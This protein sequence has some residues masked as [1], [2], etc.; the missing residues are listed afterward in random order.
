MSAVSWTVADAMLEDMFKPMT[1]AE[2]ED[3]VK[4]FEKYDAVK[5]LAKGG[6][7]AAFRVTSRADLSD[8][9]LKLAL[10]ECEEYLEEE[11]RVMLQ[12]R[13]PYLVPIYEWGTMIQSGWAGHVFPGYYCVFSGL[14]V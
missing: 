5:L 8:R 13:H 10:G 4:S 12:C 6:M 1:E 11:R 9:A 3:Q 7:G 14:I 2:W